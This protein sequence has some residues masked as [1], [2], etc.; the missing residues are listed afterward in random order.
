MCRL[1]MV[2]ELNGSQKNYVLDT[3]I[4]RRCYENP[5]YL[6]M[7]KLKIDLETSK[8]VFTT[9]S[10][11]EINNKAEYGYNDVQSKLEFVSGNK[12]STEEISSETNLLGIWLKDNI[13]ELH[14]PDNQILAFAMIKDFILVTS[15]KG[16]EKASKN[17]GHHVMNP[18]NTV[19][20]FIKTKSELAKLAN[21]K[22][23]AIKQKI[24]KTS[25]VMKKPVQKIMWRSFV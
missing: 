9:I 23:N 12:I 16:L 22:M 21:F 7:L 1:Y 10:V 8:T 15:D 24:N 20:D 25:K 3:C 4:G 13:N 5:A 2:G 11:Y 14:Y 17:V 6:D 19:I 18:D